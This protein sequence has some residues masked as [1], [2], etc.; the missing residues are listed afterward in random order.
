MSGKATA[1]RYGTLSIAMHWLMLLLI[2][3]VYLCIELR[4]NYPKGSDIREALKTWHY[5]LGMLVLVFV[6]L[7]IA[8]R[9]LGPTPSIQPTPAKWQELIAKLMH[10]ALYVLMIGQPLLG[11]L[12]LSA[13]GD[14]IPFFGLQL[15]ALIAENKDLVDVLKEVHE[16]S[17]TVGYFLVGLHAA[18]ALFHHYITRD[19][20]LVRM[21]PGRN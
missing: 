13:N 18:A 12:I 10:L 4:G 14:P 11:W 16:T 1:T 8:L 20:T 5:M 21:L 19:N 7:R 15:P 3:A 6:W 17:G 9:I 2:G